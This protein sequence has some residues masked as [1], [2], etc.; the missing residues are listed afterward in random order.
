MNCIKHN[1]S[2][3]GEGFCPLCEIDFLERTKKL[4]EGPW[5]CPGK[6]CGGQKVRSGT[7]WCN[8]CWST[9]H[10][11]VEE[12]I[13]CAINWK[14]RR[15]GYEYVSNKPFFL[16]EKH[17]KELEHNLGIHVN[18]FMTSWGIVHIEDISISI[19]YGRTLREAP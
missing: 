5:K 6:E 7:N 18:S 13:M 11:C 15:V 17:I 9:K 10:L 16:N 1:Q 2:F 8:A 19:D 14:I 12:R 3:P 4:G